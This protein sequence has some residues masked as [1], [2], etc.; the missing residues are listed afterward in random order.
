MA[1]HDPAAAARAAMPQRYGRSSR[2][3]RVALAVVLVAVVGLAAG[4]LFDA[5]RRGANPDVDAGVSAFEVVSE[6]R[7]DLTV[8]VRRAVETAVTCAV[9]AQAADKQVV[10][11]RTVELPSRPA[12]TDRFTVSISTERRAVSATVGSC[13]ASG[14]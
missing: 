6:R 10:G 4:W 3:G 5:A 8:E 9:Y 11:E 2:T 12:G 13:A 1:R 14:S 7:T